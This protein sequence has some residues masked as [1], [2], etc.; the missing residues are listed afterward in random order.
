MTLQSPAIDGYY[1]PASEDEVV[2][3]VRHA[4]RTRTPLRVVGSGHSEWAARRAGSSWSGRP[5]V[6][7]DL[8]MR[9]RS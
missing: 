2:E 1:H 6:A 7:G 9:R 4:S 5:I 8:A 3:L